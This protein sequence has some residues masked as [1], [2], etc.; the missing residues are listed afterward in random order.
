MVTLHWQP[1]RSFESE[2]ID[3]YEDIRRTNI[4][5]ALLN[6]TIKL[7]WKHRLS[8]LLIADEQF[9]PLEIDRF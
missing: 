6:V 2:D 9:P 5:L 8:L 3:I 1:V 4:K 7:T